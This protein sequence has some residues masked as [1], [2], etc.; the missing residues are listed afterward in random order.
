M[1]GRGIG[2]KPGSAGVPA[3]GFKIFRAEPTPPAGTPA[4]PATANADNPCQ[5]FGYGTSGH[6]TPCLYEERADHL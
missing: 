2:F 6:G 1:C 3:G 4:L 5:A